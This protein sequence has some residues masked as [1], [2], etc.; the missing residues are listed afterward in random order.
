M[1]YQ[2]KGL[3]AWLLQRLTGVFMAL[4][5]LC[6][7]GVVV[8]SESMNYQQWSGWL[9]HPLMNTA[10]ALFFLTLAYHTWVGMRDIVIDYV[11]NDALRLLVL[12]LISLFLISSGLYMLKI[13]FSLSLS[14]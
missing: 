10:T 9:S 13:L 2:A 11:P 6:V 3:Q 4:Y 7:L 14:V 8:F 12:T 1:S 5:I